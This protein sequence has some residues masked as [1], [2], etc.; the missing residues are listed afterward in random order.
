M[1]RWLRRATCAVAVLV[2]PACVEAP[3]PSAP[4][5][6]QAEDGALW[7][8]VPFEAHF[9]PAASDW[10]LTMG[11]ARPM[12]RVNG[13]LRELQ[14][15]AFCPLR[16]S[17]GAPGSV[18]LISDGDRVGMTP[19]ECGLS[20]FPYDTT[21]AFCVPVALRSYVEGTLRDTYAEIVSV[22]PDVGYAGY[23]FP[24]GTGA[25]PTE[26]PVDDGAPTGV[27]GGLW[28]YGTVAP[29]AQQEQTWVFEN[30]GGRF[31][32]RGRVVARVD[33]S[34]NG[35]DDDCDGRVDE[36]IGAYPV[37]EACVD[38][39]DCAS[40]VCEAGF[41]ADSPCGPGEEPDGGGG[42]VDIDECAIDNGGCG[43]PEVVTCTDQ[44]AGAAPICACDSDAVR[45]ELLTGIAS[46]DVGGALGSR[47][48]PMS[49]SAFPVVTDASGDVLAAGAYYGEGRIFAIGHEGMMNTAA[50]SDGRLDVLMR[51][52]ATW[53][54]GAGARV[55]VE[56]SFSNLRSNLSGAGFVV[57]TTTPLEL[58]DIDVFVGELW[59]D[60]TVD[61]TVALREFVAAG[62]ALLLGGHS[63]YWAYS[64]DDAYG[65]YPGNALLRG[66]GLLVT[67]NTVDTGAYGLT[68]GNHNHAICGLD[69]LAAGVG[70]AD[71]LAEAA[72]VAGEAVAFVPWGDPYLL[73]AEEAVATAG[74]VIPTRAQPL[75]EADA[76][77]RLAALVQMRRALDAP[78]IEVTAH[79]SAGDFPG[80]V[81]GDAE[82]VTRTLSIDGSFAGRDTRWSYAGSA[83]PVWRSTGLYAAPGETITVTIPASATGAGLDVQ[84]GA[85]TDRLYGKDAWERLPE[86]VRR[87]PL[88][89]RTTDVA[90]GFGGLIYVRVP[91]GASLGWID[92]TIEGA[93]EAPH[94]VVGRDTNDDWVSG[95]RDAP[96]PWAELELDTLVLTVPSADVRDLDD[97]EA[98][99]ALWDQAM[100]AIAE[101]AT[102]NPERERHERFVMDRQISAGLYHAGYPIMGHTYSVDDLVDLDAILAGGSWGPFHEI[103][104]NHQ[105]QDWLLPGTTE[106][107][108]NLYSVYVM[109]QVIARSRDDAHPALA[110]ANRASRV[111]SYLA[112][113]DFSSWSV[114]VALET[115]L[116]LQEAF[117]WDLYTSLFAEYRGLDDG[118]RATN[119]SERIQQWIV[120][121]SLAAELDLTPFYEAWDFPIDASTYDAVDGLP[122]WDAHPMQ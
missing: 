91:V 95:L 86:I 13:T 89:A 29:G 5:A 98:L 119:D 10:R 54:G 21:G 115:Y 114:W 36:G 3:A 61:E 67:P 106:T 57:R 94:F 92:V 104:H 77:E 4:S 105:Y 58:D 72:A 111:S 120:R 11:D 83:Q 12:T 80:A 43:H 46:L 117:G 90:S 88:T 16:V 33:E 1:S 51:N 25:D 56:A 53:L 42:C 2:G 70:G 79:G 84:I 55:G 48:L 81:P 17:S 47:L 116:Q 20:G 65:A 8:V 101:L 107:T 24:Y 75:R 85:H 49:R 122:T 35:T 26:V 52:A 14:A 66:T 27:A 38:A 22:A 37:G 15:G 73:A 112:S 39:T 63:W 31:S 41:C 9:D 71:V 97:P 59:N 78:A 93:V 109:E 19:S 60:Y 121:S 18:R 108:C 76:F 100:D 23:A 103:G 32:I 96:A 99:M 40:G 110:P 113:P 7:Q 50:G 68:A 87:T 45:A 64:N 102:I 6:P 62:G 34:P 82:R 118:E 74:D 44:P 28:S 30:A 69:A